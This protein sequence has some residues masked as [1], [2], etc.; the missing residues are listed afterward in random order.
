MRRVL[1]I[2]LAILL[3]AAPAIAQ[4]P[5]FAGTTAEQNALMHVET[6]ELVKAREE[7]HK[8]LKDNPKSYAGHYIMGYTLHNNEGDL[9]KAK[10][11]IKKS[12]EYFL[13]RHGQ[14]FSIDSPWGWYE[15]ALMEM[16]Q[17]NAEMDLYQEQVETLDVYQGLS[18][19]LFNLEAPSISVSYAWPLMKL[20]KEQEARAKLALV[21]S[22]PD[23]GTRTT[24]LNTLG[25]LEMEFGNPQASYSAFK[26]LIEEV[27]ANNWGQTSTYLRNLGEA[28]AGIGQWDEAERLYSEA[29]RYF[30]PLTYSNPWFDLTFLYVSQARFPEAV[31]SLQKTHQWRFSVKSFLAQQ[32]WAQ[33]MHI[34]AEL[35]MHLGETDKALEIAEMITRRPD[36]QGGDSIHR[37]QKEAGIWMLYRSITLAEAARLQESL[38]WKSG[39]QWWKAVVYR[40]KLLNDAR[41]ATIKVRA[42]ASNHRRLAKSLR[43]Y[44][45]PGTFIMTDWHRPDLVTVYGAGVTSEALHEIYQKPPESMET[46]RPALE[47]VRAEVAWAR[48]DE[49]EAIE[50]LKKAIPE[51]GEARAVLR[52]RAEARLAGILFEESRFEEAMEYGTRVLDTAP[53]MFRH[54]D[55]SLPVRVESDGDSVSKEIA[56]A[57]LDSPRFHSD[58]RGYPVKIRSGDGRLSAALF[59]PQ[60]ALM[61]EVSVDAVKKVPKKPQPTETPGPDAEEAEEPE[62]LDPPDE[63]VALF[64]K[65]AFAPRLDLSQSQINSLDG[66][67]LTDSRRNNKA[68]EAIGLPN[69]RPGDRADS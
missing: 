52:A 69:L 37:D 56:S 55:I 44:Y 16:V 63:L 3:F 25:A 10:F 40:R 46:E 17:I 43:P 4:N 31:S 2:I 19:R 9:P 8:I 11:H 32:T 47:V 22:Y 30:N 59:S 49:D 12:L 5:R 51:V 20:E 45:A 60:Q 65:K 48:G 68:R 61:A 34:T 27:R 54:L 35:L 33:D 53:A 15:R 66:S 62:I 28:A 13:Q 6:D 1:L 18:R 7:A 64:H 29:T 38:S 41:M 42:L 67:T 39:W 26:K 24:Y 50:I 36:R 23:E 58:E 14:N 21:S 57:I